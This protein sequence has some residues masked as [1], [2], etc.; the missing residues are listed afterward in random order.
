MDHW[1]SVDDKEIKMKRCPKCR[2][3]EPNRF[4]MTTPRYMNTVKKTFRDIQAVK[5]KVFGQ[6][7]EIRRNRE[8]LLEKLEEVPG[9]AMNDF[10]NY[11]SGNVL[12]NKLFTI[13]WGAR[14]DYF[15][16]ELRL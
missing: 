1:I 6:I 8:D 4:L 5:L 14:A 7:Q 13:P 15:R 16:V 9:H 2:P 12:L 3:T 11:D 10:Q